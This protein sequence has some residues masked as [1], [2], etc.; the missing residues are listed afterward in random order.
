[1]NIFA[2]LAAILGIP[3]AMATANDNAVASRI[4][5]PV[6]EAARKRLGGQFA[7]L[8]IS[9]TRWYLSDLEAAEMA[10]DRGDLSIAGRLMRAARKDGTFAG[11]LATRT[12]G[13]VRL[14]K[15]F[16]GDADLVD[17]LKVGHDSIRSVF[18]EM[19]PPTELANLI[20]DGILLGVGVG[21][22]EPV[23]GR[24]YPV[25]IRLEPENLRYVWTENRWYYTTLVGR[26]LV[27]PGMGRWVLHTP[28]GRVAPWNHGLWRATGQSWIDK[29]HA[30]YCKSNYESKL[31]NP[32]R[33]AV[34]PQGAA[35]KQ[36]QSW[37]KQVMA[38][39]INSVFGVTPGYDVKLLESNGKGWECFVETIKLSDRDTVI[40]VTGS[41]VLVDGGTGFSN[42][43][44]HKAIRADLIKADAEGAAYTLNTQGLPTW[45]LTSWD[46]SK[47]ETSVIVEWDIDQPEDRTA[48]A[49][50]MTQ[51]ASA[52]T[53]LN[54][55]LENSEDEVDVAEFMKR[56]SVPLK[57]RAKG[58][59]VANSKPSNASTADA[60][61]EAA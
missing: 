48:E 44:V 33:V 32:A 9:Q 58:P 25:F 36:K 31:A 10:A 6:V 60:A 23:P 37:F 30:R 28:G 5:D 3:V 24:S 52:L 41:T 13:L 7:P 16:R 22:L 43:D 51:A 8:P 19:F 20:A 21:I 12:G 47:L 18:D 26:V 61:K 34:S 42:I 50:T 38:W 4:D 59:G 29:Q 46:E 40:S 54:A 17:A 1:M 56:F 57:K 14:P 35:E 2:K 53:Q 11:V 39:G 49:T 55:A 27:E 45:I 15:K